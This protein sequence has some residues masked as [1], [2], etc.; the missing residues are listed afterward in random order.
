MEN[1]YWFKQSKDSP[2]FPDLLWSRPETK[3][4]AGKLLI[5]GGNIHGF[6][7][8]GQAYTAAQKA[9]AGSIRIILPDALQKTVSK[10]MPEADYA[11]STP[12]GS[13][14]GQ[15]L[16]SFLEHAA[17]ADSVLLAGDFGRNSET[18][19]SLEKLTSKYDG[20]I[21]VVKDAV[22]YFTSSPESIKDRADTTLVL[23]MAQ[24]QRLGQAFKY[25][26]PF[27]FDMDLLHLVET[28]HGFT[29]KFSINIV[30][31]HLD[32]LFVAVTGQVSTTKTD[33][34]DEES[35]RIPIATNAAV[36]WLQNPS[37]TFEAITSSVI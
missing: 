12:S 14:S 15:A 10:L 19:I 4:T 31:K 5:V 3:H 25:T 9:G 37:K 16:A 6:A 26:K 11:P 22:D 24:L 23:T 30:I 21:A 33:L 20:Q 17:W 13:F 27:T 1:T 7:A 29:E 2:L 36:W 28:L 34:K 8:V 18:A 35:W 32:T